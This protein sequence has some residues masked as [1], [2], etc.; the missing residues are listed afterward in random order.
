VLLPQLA[1][2]LEFGGTYRVAD[3][4]ERFD[5]ANTEPDR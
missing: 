2:A 1:N 5:L 3:R 4:A